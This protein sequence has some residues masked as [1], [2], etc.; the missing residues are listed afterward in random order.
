M[1]ATGHGQSDALHKKWSRA[2][3]PRIV[4]LKLAK[5]NI[6][7]GRKNNFSLCEQKT[8]TWETGQNQRNVVYR[9]TQ[10]NG[11]KNGTQKMC[12]PIKNRSSCS[13]CHACGKMGPNNASCWAHYMTWLGF[14]ILR[15]YY[16]S[17]RN[18]RQ[19]LRN[20]LQFLRSPFLCG[21]CLL[22]WAALLATMNGCRTCI[23]YG[24]EH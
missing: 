2:N 1:W 13:S 12:G 7:K 11:A 22:K 21:P 3:R 9:H 15:L 6:E 4:K 16:E 24:V 14:V 20:I 17:R 5:N 23:F 10:K 18:V 19:L 8:S